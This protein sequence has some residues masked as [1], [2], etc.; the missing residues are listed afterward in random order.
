M[1]KNKKN[2]LFTSNFWSKTRISFSSFDE[3]T[4]MLKLTYTTIVHMKMF[5]SNNYLVYIESRQDQRDRVQNVYLFAGRG[6]LIKGS[7]SFPIYIEFFFPFKR[8][9]C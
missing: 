5:K 9:M 8:P 1:W 4:S 6:F 3:V 7:S 2:T